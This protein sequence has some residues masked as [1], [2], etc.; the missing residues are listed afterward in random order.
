[1]VATG[2]FREDLFHRLGEMIVQIPPLHERP[3]DVLLLARRFLAAE[4]HTGGIDEVAA[5]V[6]ERRPWRGNGRELRNWMRRAAAFSG[7][8]AIGGEL[9][10]RLDIGTVPGLLGQNEPGV[11]PIDAQ[12]PIREAR[13]RWL[14]KLEREYLL[15]VLNAVG[16][17]LEMVADHI[18]LSR[19]SVF[20]LLRQHGLMD[21]D[22]KVAKR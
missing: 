10:E 13:Q 11:V 21:A 3:G 19:K 5:R 6:L 8:E 2:A 16:G 18:E 1:M 17:D 22:G 20:R 15:Q 7:G 4:H 12:L 9:L 14:D